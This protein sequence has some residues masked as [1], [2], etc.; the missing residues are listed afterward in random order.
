MVYDVV[1]TQ[2]AEEDLDQFLNYLIHEK[3]NLEAA[4]NV[5]DDFDNTVATLKLVAG[6]LKLCDNPRLHKLNYR[7]MNFLKHRYFMLYRVVDNI[8]YVDNVFHELQDFESR[9]Y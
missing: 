1:V 4:K 5:L 8:V 6:S 9:M 2:E 7:R 3:G